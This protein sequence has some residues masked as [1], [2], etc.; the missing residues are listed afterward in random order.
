M[1]QI[2]PKM[3][4]SL[5]SVKTEFGND[6][7]CWDDGIGPAWIM[8]DSMGIVGVIIAQTWETA[9]ECAIDELLPD[10]E[11]PPLDFADDHEAAC[12]E[13]ANSWRGSGTPSNPALKLPVAAHDLNGE[14]LE[15]LTVELV[16]KLGLKLKFS[17]Q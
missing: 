4:S 11:I 2:D 15:P 9:Y 13:E 14:T 10:G 3:S 17:N 1:K 12:W 7:P 16:R 6:V 8:R 5:V